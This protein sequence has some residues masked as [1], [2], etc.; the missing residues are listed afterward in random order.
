M[1]ISSIAVV[2]L[3]FATLTGCATHGC[4]GYACKRPDSTHRELVIWWP[5]DMRDG[6]DD[7]DHE[8]DYTV[9]KLKD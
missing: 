6:L 9:V 5:P 2:L 1:K 8:R 4:S 7:Q 3:V